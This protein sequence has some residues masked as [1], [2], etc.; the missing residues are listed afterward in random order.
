M[1]RDS[2]APEPAI[3]SGERDAGQAAEVHDS[4]APAKD[5]HNIFPAASQP[6]VDEGP[7][8]KF[9]F[10]RYRGTWILLSLFV[11]VISLAFLIYPRRSAIYRPQ[12][13]VVQVQADVPVTDI[14][15]SV[16]KQAPKQFNLGVVVD[17][18][19]PDRQGSVS[20]TV[21]AT[22]PSPVTRQSCAA[23]HCSASS[24]SNIVASEDF[25]AGEAYYV[26]DDVT[27]TK[28]T[29]TADGHADWR[30][31]ANLVVDAPA[32]AW[33]ENG[34]DVEAQLPEVQLSDPHESL[35][36][37]NVA[38]AYYLPSGFDWTGGPSPVYANT[39]HMP[40][41][42]LA[43]GGAMVWVQSVKDLPNPIPASG[44]DNSAAALDSTRTFISG[45]LL[46]IAGGALVG[47]IQETTHKK[48]RLGPR[49]GPL[50]KAA[51]D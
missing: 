31:I 41:A 35:N 3:E 26:K 10:K 1:E 45:A 21:D 40:G 38:I 50:S 48:R 9:Y 8:G 37:P 14:G 34:L 20:V 12:P 28:F 19:S 44:T 18:V 13:F 6:T 15:V 2:T 7:I 32:F 33:D 36:G 29:T 30:S 17:T 47:A 43:P 23:P 51:R 42:Y 24:I 22:L 27:A 49:N 25:F 5:H 46:G 4:P 11:I 16:V 39:F